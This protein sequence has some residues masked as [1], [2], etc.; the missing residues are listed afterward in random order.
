M[1]HEENLYAILTLSVG[2]RTP[3]TENLIAA[4]PAD[5][6]V[7]ASAEDGQLELLRKREEGLPGEPDPDRVFEL[8]WADLNERYTAGRTAPEELCADMEAIARTAAEQYGIFGE[9]WLS[10][11]SM[12]T[13]RRKTESGL[14]APRTFELA[15]QRFLEEKTT[16]T[17]SN[18]RMAHGCFMRGGQN[19]LMGIF[20]IG[21]GGLLLILPLTSL[22]KGEGGLW[23]VLPAVFVIAAG[24]LILCRNRNA[25]FS[26]EDDRVTARYGLGRTLDVALG[27]VADVRWRVS[28]V[29][30]L[31][32]RGGA[33]AR[34]GGLSNAAFLGTFLRKKLGLDRV[35]GTAAE[36][37][38]QWRALR[39]KRRRETAGLIACLVVLV[40]VIAA[41]MVLTGLRSPA[42]FTPTE[43]TVA[44]LGIA[45]GAASGAGAYLFARS[46]GDK[47]VRLIELENAGRRAAI[48]GTPLCPGNMLAVYSDP[49]FLGRVT[50]YS[51]PKS[52]EVYYVTERVEGD[53]AVKA[54]TSEF[55]PSLQKLEPLLRELEDITKYFDTGE[56]A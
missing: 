36:L 49:D 18:K 42:V 45:L 20:L 11:A 32:L 27:E 31:R 47:L 56:S 13:L 30:I 39:K 21:A 34:I 16:L 15:Y 41:V 51:M 48:L 1:N 22:F 40:G 35:E 37:H 7:R 8:V 19:G 53:E 2:W 3:Q 25:F 43:W 29:L 14:I 28:G 26:V 12:E 55:F 17:E 9:P 33:A 50:V 52:N 44:A 4:L 54:Y 6:P 10:L 5:D 38:E 23:Y 46:A 24:V